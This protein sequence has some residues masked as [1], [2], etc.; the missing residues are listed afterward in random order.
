MPG[1][2]GKKMMQGISENGMSR[3]AGVSFLRL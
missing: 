3:P 1:Q 2:Y